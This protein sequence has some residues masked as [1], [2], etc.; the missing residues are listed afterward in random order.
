MQT[1]F[2]RTRGILGILALAA[3]WPLGAQAPG[4]SRDIHDRIVAIMARAG[5]DEPA[6]DTFVT[7]S[8]RPV[9]YHTVSREPDQVRTALIRADGLA[10]VADVQFAGSV[11]TNAQVTWRRGGQTLRSIQLQVRRD[12]LHV[13]DSVLQV[14]PIP[15]D[16]W[17]IADYG[18][19]DLLLPVLGALEHEA[20]R[21]IAVYRPY[22]AKWDTLQVRSNHTGG[23]RLVEI[24]S[25][26]DDLWTLVLGDDDT[27]IQILRSKYPDFE[28]RPIEESRR[29]AEYMAQRRTPS[30]ES[31]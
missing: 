19:E 8:P 7:W 12:S 4:S 23:R 16:E 26:P 5:L 18:M 27:I 29:V 14:Y 6:A 31:P 24:Q 9:L 20:T 1:L 17:L 2:N 10:G 13:K 22:A 3:A 21:T 11:P 30:P 25:A 28:R 15:S